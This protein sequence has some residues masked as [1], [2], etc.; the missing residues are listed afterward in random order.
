MGVV[1]IYQARDACKNL[2][3]RLSIGQMTLEESMV[4]NEERTRKGR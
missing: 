4:L 3:G 1:V 2:L